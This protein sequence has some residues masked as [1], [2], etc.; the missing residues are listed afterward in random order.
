MRGQSQRAHNGVATAALRH[1]WATGGLA[2][3]RMRAGVPATRVEGSCCAA[4]RNEQ[5]ASL[6]MAGNQKGAAGCFAASG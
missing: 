1:C 3:F 2:V 6:V 4:V 5:K